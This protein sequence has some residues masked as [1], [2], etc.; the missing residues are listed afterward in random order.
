VF[1]K[2]LLLDLKNRALLEKSSQKFIRVNEE[3]GCG[4]KAGGDGLV[5]CLG[6]PDMKTQFDTWQWTLPF[7]SEK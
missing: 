4:G 1:T 6:L 2:I 7:R 5:F 3:T